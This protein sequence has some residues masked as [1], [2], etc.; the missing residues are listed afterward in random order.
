M[1]TTVTTALTYPLHHRPYPCL[2]N[3]SRIEDADLGVPFALGL[4]VCDQGHR[5]V[6]PPTIPNGSHAGRCDVC[7]RRL[8]RTAVTV[9]DRDRTHRF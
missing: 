9:V 8:A 2:C 3:R 6:G 5:I 1:T 4:W 7:G